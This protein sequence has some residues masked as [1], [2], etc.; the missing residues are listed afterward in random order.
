M[1]V[2]ESYALNSSSKI[3]KPFVYERYFPLATPKYITID[4]DS[5]TQSKAYNYWQEVVDII[6]PALERQGIDIV[7]IG[8][9]EDRYIENC[10][11]TAGQASFNQTAYIIKRSSLH[12]GIDNFASDL[13]SHYDKKIVCLFSNTFSK[14]SKPY[15][16]KQGDVA[17]IEPDRKGRKPSFMSFAPKPEIN[18]IMPHEIVEKVLKALKIK[19]EFPY[20]YSYIGSFYTGGHLG[21][22]PDCLISSY[23][24]TQK[25]IAIRMDLHFDEKY[26]VENLKII[27]GVIITNKPINP[28]IISA[29]KPKIKEL[30]YILEKENDPAFVKFLKN[31]GIKYT[32]VSYLEEKDIDP[33]KIDYMDHGIILPQKHPTEKSVRKEHKFPKE[34]LFYKSNKFLLSKGKVYPGDHAWKKDLPMK[35]LSKEILPI[36]DHPD[37]WK[38]SDNFCILTK[39]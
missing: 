39:K 17:E 24:L 33:L 38:D 25:Q 34:N 31:S 37:F 9:K 4:T 11:N 23:P 12:I 30:V 22:I 19:N 2:L 26:L 16:S 13:A 3:S 14:N 35:S 29:F 5:R 18:S 15:W 8:T 32:L 6:H 10:Y 36:E 28:Q 7:Q 1:H 27:D 20:K 21:L